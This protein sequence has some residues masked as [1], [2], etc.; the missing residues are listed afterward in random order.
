MQE[1]QFWE[2][3][4]MNIFLFGLS[5]YDAER[6]NVLKDVEILNGNFSQLSYEQTVQWLKNENNPMFSY[7]YTWFF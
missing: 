3:R 1:M 2:S 5:T 6:R 7:I 4:K